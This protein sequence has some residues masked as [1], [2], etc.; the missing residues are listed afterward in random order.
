MPRQKLS[1]RERLTLVGVIVGSLVSTIVG[2][3]ATEAL[4]LLLP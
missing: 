3:A 4:H 2:A 1:R